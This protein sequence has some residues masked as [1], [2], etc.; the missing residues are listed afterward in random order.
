MQGSVQGNKTSK[1]VILLCLPDEEI[2]TRDPETGSGLYSW[3]A[4]AT[5]Q[6]RNINKA[7]SP[8]LAPNYSV[9]LSA[10]TPVRPSP[11]LLPSQL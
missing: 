2:K 6:S 11:C 5:F 8:C 3:S 7:M 10:V 4:R 9:D 1:L